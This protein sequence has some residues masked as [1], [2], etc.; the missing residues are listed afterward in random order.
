MGTVDVARLKRVASGSG[1][2]V[3]RGD[4]RLPEARRSGAHRP[5]V[6]KHPVNVYGTATAGRSQTV[7]SVS[8]IYRRQFVD[9]L[10][11]TPG[12]EFS[13]TLRLP[14]NASRDG[15]VVSPLSMNPAIG[16]I[17]TQLRTISWTIQE[18]SDRPW[19]SEPSTIDSAGAC[20]IRPDYGGDA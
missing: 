2:G 7:V 11:A 17:W 5:P 12:E 1:G 9:P 20:D 10:S 18:D 14:D 19:E 3:R 16:E 15:S 13:Q 4:Q 6:G 8:R